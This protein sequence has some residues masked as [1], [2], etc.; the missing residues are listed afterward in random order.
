MQE[1]PAGDKTSHEH[2]MQGKRTTAA[3]AES[4]VSRVHVHALR[5]SSVHVWMHYTEAWNNAI[6][7]MVKEEAAESAV[8]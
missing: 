5:R 2:C 6:P 7:F 3:S 4:L 1:G 8:V